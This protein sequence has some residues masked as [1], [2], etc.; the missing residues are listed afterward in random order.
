VLSIS[1]TLA[2]RAYSEEDKRSEAGAGLQRLHRSAAQW[3]GQLRRNRA[4]EFVIILFVALTLAVSA[5]A[6]DSPPAMALPGQMNVTP[7]GA[8][9][10]TIPIAVPPGTAGMAPSLSMQYSSQNG[11]G[12]E[13]FRWS[14][15]GLPSI[16]RCPRTV[17]QDAIH[18]GVNYDG[19]DRFCLAGQRLI[20]VNG[21][22]HGGHSYGDDGAEYRTEV[23][24]FS[25]IVSH[26]TVD[27]Q[28]ATWFQV[29]TKSGQIMEFGNTVDSRAPVVWV[30]PANPAKIVRVWGVN[31]ISDTKGNYLKVY[32]LT[33]TG[34][35]QDTT[36]GQLYPKQIN[37]T[38][39]ANSSPQ[40]NPYNSIQFSYIDKNA[41]VPTYQA[42]GFAETRVLLSEIKTCISTTTC[43]TVSDYK[44]T[45][46]GNGVA[47]IPISCCCRR[48]RDLLTRPLHC[49]I[50]IRMKATP[51][52]RKLPRGWP[53]GTTTAP[54]TSSCR[55]RRGT[56]NTCSRSRPI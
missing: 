46:N 51:M 18:G 20:L 34:G 17:A 44:L 32:Y 54:A 28:G 43:T 29:W 38:G 39:N 49:P 13:G 26:T 24:N 2:K 47:V 19:N 16:T 52:V 6:A 23:N 5:R 3:I 37:Y 36:Y 9:T 56:S 55:N 15:V 45:Y 8:F 27:I 30:N 48:A 1:S 22:G 4:F 7:T 21:P 25:K 10:Y 12:F 35:T 11:D 14:L 33:A 31:K 42:G 50:R 40:L 53:T 41:F